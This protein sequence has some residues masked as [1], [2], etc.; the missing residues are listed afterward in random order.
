MK[1]MRISSQYM[2]VEHVLEFIAAINDG[3][4][5]PQLLM[6]TCVNQTNVISLAN[7]EDSPQLIRV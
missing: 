6:M 7:T 3:M 4:C 1:Y 5:Q 2:N